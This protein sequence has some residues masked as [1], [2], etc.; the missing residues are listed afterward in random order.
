MKL[1]H[2]A[3]N[4]GQFVIN[5]GAAN[6]FQIAPATGE[7]TTLTVEAAADKKAT[8]QLKGVSLTSDGV[9]K[10]FTISDTT[11]DLATMNSTHTALS[12]GLS[13]AK[14]AVFGGNVTVGSGAAGARAMTISSAN[15]MATLL[16]K[17]TN[18]GSI[19]KVESADAALSTLQL[20]GDADN[21]KLVH[22]ASNFTIKD[23]NTNTELLKIESVSAVTTLPGS[24]N[25]GSSKADVA[26]NI[27]VQSGSNAA[28]QQRSVLQKAF[29]ESTA[30]PNP[31]QPQSPKAQ[32][33][34][35]RVKSQFY[36]ILGIFWS[37]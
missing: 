11:K 18:A 28:A 32:K 36:K 3:A 22:G 9:K 19:V 14:T 16:V 20:G 8:L 26:R 10:S 21:V 13:V 12:G 4:G 33:E 7:S 29:S 27:K 17:S 23:K 25:V 30:T 15:A 1:K 5:N 6:L 37:F 31:S 35:K 34:G 2:E 24:V